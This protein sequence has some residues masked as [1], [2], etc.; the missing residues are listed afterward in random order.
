MIKMKV[1]MALA[2]LLPGFALAGVDIAQPV[3]A[4]GPLA[5]LLLGG[6]LAFLL[7]RKK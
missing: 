5:L 4:P 6:A 3:P 7:K 1:V 2:C